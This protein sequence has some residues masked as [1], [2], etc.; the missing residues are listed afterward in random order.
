MNTDLD[1]KLLLHFSGKVVKKELTKRIKEGQNVPIYV[2]EYLLGQYCA[3]DDQGIAEDGVEKVKKILASNYVRPDE[4]EKVKSKIKEMG[5]YTI[6]D[7]VKV[8]LD[9]K[10]DA[11]V[12]QFSNLG[13]KDV[14]INPRYVQ[15]Y[16][17]LLGGGV[18]CI[19]N[20]NYLYDEED[21]KTSPFRIK[22]LKPIQMPNLDLNEYIEK[23][24]NFSRDEWIDILL[25][26][27]GMEPTQFEDRVKW[28]FIER[29]V[30]LVENNYNYCELG[31]RS[32]GKSHIY[33]EISPNSIL[34][35]GGQ[36]TVA[37]LFY[38][39]STNTIGLVGLWDV[40]AFDE[41]A[42]IRFKDKDGI[43][44]MKGY[45]ASGTFSRGKESKT[46]KASMVFVGNIN[47]SIESLMRTSHLFAPF[48]PEINNDTAF[49]DRI[50]YYLPGWEIPKF[51]PEHFSDNYGFIVDYLAEVFRELR[52]SSYAD[53]YIKFFKLGNN[54]NQRDTIA[55]KKTFS[56]L[57]KLLHPDGK[58]TKKEA[59]DML[60][61][62]LEG[63]RRV[64]EQ[65][66]KIGGMEFYDV[67]FSY[68][69]LDAEISK[70]HFISLPE[71]GSSKLIP[72]G[73]M[74][75]G[76]VHLIG[77]SDSG[78]LG[79]YKI[80][81]QISRGSGRFEKSG[82]NSNSKS[83]EKVGIAYNYFRAN[84]KSISQVISIKEKNYHL[85]FQ[86]LQ[87]I[88]MTDELSLSTFIA[89]CSAAM[90]R[91][92]QE[93]MVI[94]GNMTIGGTIEKVNNLADTLQVCFDAGV[95]KIL[96]PMSAANSISGVPPE[97]FS[98][99]QTS[100]YQDPIDAVYKALGVE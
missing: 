17:K 88:G 24:S 18:W 85:Q 23:R 84:A 63:R 29:L 77:K 95:K 26:S 71:K 4:A 13:L 11:Y 1:A 59:E 75:P 91:S 22:S 3:T 7:M 78:M 37:N 68:I 65:L 92:V 54:L 28:H 81:T 86:D 21:K 80:E 67:Q 61:Y 53:G 69:D 16:E 32:T 97:L 10:K 6:I 33:Q 98:K 34:I 5:S 79:V 96:L 30:P 45:M 51:R 93:Q 48:P 40:V 31:P 9:E 52:K 42:G 36:T 60:K 73:K 43:Q 47:Q 46:A 76:T 62:A 2:L 87:S 58:Y 8:R 56:G 70:E 83:K 27:I 12:A 64:K 100:F 14:R 35:S 66:K 89:L 57:A 19:L 82:L 44:I 39:M 90:D 99:F 20:M 50:H 72:E 38:N 74:N 25:R 55:V 41:V 15:D 94:L 49:F